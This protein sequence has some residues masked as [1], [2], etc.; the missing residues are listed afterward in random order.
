M[1]R[2]DYPCT[3]C[4]CSVTSA[5]INC[6]DIFIFTKAIRSGKKFLLLIFNTIIIFCALFIFSWSCTK[7]AMKNF[8]APSI[9]A[10]TCSRN[11][12]L[13]WTRYNFLTRTATLDLIPLFWNIEL[14]PLSSCARSKTILSNVLFVEKIFNVWQF[15]LKQ[16]F[17]L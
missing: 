14:F 7:S 11:L 8:K 9:A 1:Y 12:K 4:L 13:K 15:L 2:M 6:K 10:M 16:E 5:F 17:C 3:L